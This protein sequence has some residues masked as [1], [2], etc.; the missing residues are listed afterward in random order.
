MDLFDVARRQHGVFHLDQAR[1]LGVT[2]RQM[3]TLERRGVIER[4]HP[5][6]LRVRAARSTVRQ[7]TSAATLWLP[8]SLASHRTAA[9]LWGSRGFES[10]P[11]E[12]V[13]ERWTRRQRPPG[14]ILHETKDLVAADIAEVDGIACTSLV[15]TLI[16]LP[17]VVSSERA[18]TALDAAIRRDTT[19]LERVAQRH[20]EVARRGRNGT[21][22]M[23]EL[24][25]E[26]GAGPLIVDSGFERHALTCVR[27]GGLPTPVTQLKITDGTD[28]CFLDLAWPLW[29]VA[30]ECDSLEYHLNEAAFRWERRRRR[31]LAA[32]GWITLEFTYREVTRDPAR[33]VRD[34]SRHLT[35][36][37]RLVVAASSAGPPP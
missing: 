1:A 16:D 19:L 3:R 8:G 15:R 11:A 30:M 31:M 13:T 28:T 32:L 33:V 34:L 4:V 20:R 36:A 26:R 10:T 35:E 29:K 2:D 22:I 25:R 12:I 37:R 7:R 27:E 6:V 21:V 17:A 24:L 14:L 18:G 5:G 9:G 23:R